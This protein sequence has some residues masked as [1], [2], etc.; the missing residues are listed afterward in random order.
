MEQSTARYLIG[1]NILGEHIMQ[2]MQEGKESKSNHRVSYLP[3]G[4]P[5]QAVV[6]FK[7]DGMPP[8]NPSREYMLYS[9]YK[10]LDIAVPA[11]GI[12]IIDHIKFA[13]EYNKEP[14][15]L[16]ASAA[17]QGISGK[18]ILKENQ[19]IDLDIDHFSKQVLGALITGP[20]DGKADNYVVTSLN[21]HS[22]D[23]S[24]PTKHGWISIDNDEVFQ[25]PIDKGRAHLKS[26]L[27]LLPSMKEL[28]GNSI[29]AWL[30]QLPINLVIL[31]WLAD[32]KKQEAVYR[33]LKEDLLQ[34]SQPGKFSRKG[35]SL[36]L[37]HIEAIWQDLQL[38]FLSFQDSIVPTVVY[39]LKQIQTCVKDHQSVKLGDLFKY[40]YPNISKY[41]ELLQKNSPSVYA[42][43]ELLY[44]GKYAQENQ[45]QASIG[46]NLNDNMPISTIQATKDLSY[47][48][49]DETHPQQPNI[50]KIMEDWLGKTQQ[51]DMA[52]AVD[53]TIQ[54]YLSLYK[55]KE[56]IAEKALHS[57]ETLKSYGYHQINDTKAAVDLFLKG[58]IRARKAK[59]EATWKSI[60]NGFA[61]QNPDLAWLLN[62]EKHMA[63]GWPHADKQP[64]SIYEIRGATLGRRHLSQGVKEALLN[65]A[66]TFQADASLP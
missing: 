43:L 19:S 44:D 5:M 58:L 54:Y 59:K 13:E 29:K 39:L 22:N 16:Q 17:I 38:P 28:L 1:K 60:F 15:I 62:I 9:L 30:R 40:C 46:T 4:N 63:P 45:I 37:D 35:G 3:A 61:K 12:L 33:Y 47:F 55:N 14:Y 18:K 53:Q 52:F 7:N 41:Y 51:Q 56:D 20:V 65:Q 11:S 64:R 27:F 2:V 50:D 23:N 66:G 48:Q 21:K 25:S 36:K 6:Y 10:R 34:R 32:L 8:L 42:A 57:L 24:E 26:V 31:E 49:R